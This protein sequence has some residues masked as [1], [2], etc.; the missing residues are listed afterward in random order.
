MKFQTW[1]ESSLNELKQ[2]ATLAFPNTNKRQ[3]AINEIEISSIKITPYVGVKT[4]YTKALAQNVTNGKEYNS[5]ILF[6]GLDYQEQKN[7]KNI[8]IIAD[9]IHYYFNQLSLEDTQVLLRC[10]CEDFKNR[11]HHYNYL[12]KSLQGPNRKKY[13]GQGLWEANPLHLPGMCKH[14]MKLVESLRES[15]FFT[16]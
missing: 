12:D 8:E 15:N 3:H 4:L 13:I 11:F 10:D 7:K 16:E 6:K 1:L 5:I 9:G 2:S 14:L